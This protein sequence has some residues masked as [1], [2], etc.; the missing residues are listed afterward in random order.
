[1]GSGKTTIGKLI[2]NELGLDLIEMDELLLELSGFKS[3]NEIFENHGETRFREIEI[4]TAKTLSGKE[5]CL[6]ST[7]GGVVMN[8]IIIDYLKKSNEKSLVIFLNA[9]FETLRKR[10][11]G[12][13]ARP[14][15]QDVT[16]AKKLY[17]FRLPLYQEYADIEISTDEKNPS[18]IA[19]EILDLIKK[20]R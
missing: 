7:G 16:K 5:D 12:D 2:A 4:E 20:S 6:I 8:K 15:F 13:N 17:D 3:I 14:L 18:Q 10:L 11:E 9:K 19:K 1:M